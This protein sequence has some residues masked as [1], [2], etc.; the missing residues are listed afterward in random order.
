M[1]RNYTEAAKDFL[2]GFSED[3]I[4]EFEKLGKIDEEAYLNTVAYVAAQNVLGYRC[5][6]D[7][8]QKK[9]AKN[10]ACF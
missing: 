9:I 2:A 5:K 10:L 3:F 6:M 4:K 1:K 7:G 8:K